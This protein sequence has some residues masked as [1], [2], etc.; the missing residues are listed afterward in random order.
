MIER[1]RFWFEWK[2]RLE[3]RKS[4]KTQNW[5]YWRTQ[6]TVKRLMTISK[7][8][9]W[10][11]RKEIECHTNRSQE[12]SKGILAHMNC[13]FNGKEGEIFCIVLPLGMQNGCI[14]LFLSEEN[15]GAALANHPPTTITISNIRHSKVMLYIRVWRK[16]S[17]IWSYPKS[18]QIITGD[19]YWQQF[20]Q[21]NRGSKIK[22][23]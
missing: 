8:L 19:R 4:L 9:E 23:S 22:L 14:T 15:H 1:W 11:K 6:I 3:N 21:L 18:D 20:L 13:S 10:F 2:E 16:G 12:A 7:C 5:R 17:S